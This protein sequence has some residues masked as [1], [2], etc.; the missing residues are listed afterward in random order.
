[1]LR[2]L[3]LICDQVMYIEL[4]IGCTMY[5]TC[6]DVRCT[7]HRL[8]VTKTYLNDVPVTLQNWPVFNKLTQNN[9]AL[10]GG[11]SVLSCGSI[12][13]PGLSSSVSSSQYTCKLLMVFALT[14]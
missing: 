8:P 11:C 9:D 6:T 13:Y 3:W 5:C 2:I 7:I 4:M 14:E 12:D 1:M 10:R